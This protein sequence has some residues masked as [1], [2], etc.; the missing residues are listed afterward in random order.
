MLTHLTIRDFTLIDHLELELNR[1]MTVISGETG[2][3][4][5]IM[6]DALGLALGDRAEADMVRTGCKRAE[7]SACFDISQVPE[8][9]TWLQE[10]DLDNGDD[11]I[12][13]R[14]VGANG[15]SRAYI[16]GNPCPLQSL[17]GLSEHLADLHGQHEH[18]RLL[19]KEHHRTLL[20]AF[21]GLD[22]L[23]A[24]TAR[25]YRHW[26]QLDERLKALRSRS[27]EDSAREQLLRYQVQELD[28]LAPEEDELSALEA[29][30]KQL[31]NAEQLLQGGEQVRQLTTEGD[32]D[33]CASLLNQCLQQLDALGLDD[34][35]LASTAEM[36]NSALIQVEEASNELGHFLGNVELNPQRLQTV[37]ERLS[38]F[39]QIARKHREDPAQLPTLHLRLSEELA[40]MSLSDEALATLEEETREAERDYRSAAE[41]LSEQRRATAEQLQARVHEQLALLGMPACRFEAAL[42]PVAPRPFGLEE[43]EFLISTNPGQPPKPLSRVASGGE[44]SRISLAIQVVTAQVAATPVLAFDEVDVGIGGAI[45][46]V[47]GRLL[48]GL[49]ERCQVL[50]V[51]HQPQVA[52]RGHQHLQVEKRRDADSTATRVVRLEKKQRVEEIARMLAGIDITQRSLDHAEEMLALE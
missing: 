13:R 34:P 45:A 3:G 20:D 49:G 36:L 1:G 6:L 37:E 29:E 7:I 9:L 35:A 4:K 23:A 15:R 8:A 28:Q 5:S 52:S 48:R 14:V 10:H 30:Q 2:A 38:L 43:P 41:E 39:Y 17:K 33:N 11:C 44:L 18:Q 32:T 22:P 26:H 21:G 46:E 47:V 16:N 31:A 50:C 25:A 51:T 19:R 42:A 27:D 12:L 40:Q 24:R